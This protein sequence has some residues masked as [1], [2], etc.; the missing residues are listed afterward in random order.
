MQYFF[1][2]RNTFHNKRGKTNGLMTMGL[3]VLITYIITHKQLPLQK[4]GMAYE[5]FQSGDR[6][7]FLMCGGHPAEFSVF[8][9][10]ATNI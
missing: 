6:K 10:S 5:R 9:E 8:C 3:P 7:H 1:W 4:G 2:S